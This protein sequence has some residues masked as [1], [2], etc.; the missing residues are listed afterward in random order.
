MVNEKN[1]D[2][3]SAETVHVHHTQE[4]SIAS[5]ALNHQFWS[6]KEYLF[7][8][9]GILI[10]AIMY[11]FEV[12]LMYGCIGNITA[13]FE[14]SSLSS[15]LPTILQIL[16][17]ALVPFYTKVSDVTGRAQALTFAMVFYLIGYTIQGTS[18][19]FLQ[20]ALG[21]IAYGIGSTG[22]ATL[23]QV[24]I[25]DSTL[26]INR[27]IVFAL[28][29]LPSAAMIFIT[30]PLIDPLSNFVMY[31][32][33]NWRNVYLIIGLIALVGAFA[34]LTPLWY[35]QRK[36]ERRLKAAGEVVP[37]RTIGWL[38]HEF[39]TV[40]ALLITLGMSLTLLPMILARSF[41][42]NWGNP[43]ILAMFICGVIFLFLLV[44]WEVK[45]TDRPIMSMKIWGNRTAFGGLVVG[46]VMTVMASMNWQYYTLYLVVSRDISFSSALLL[47]RGY[48]LAYL[49]F[50]LGTALLMKRFNT[51]RP[52]IWVGIVVHTI[53]I[54]LM[55]P[56]RHPDSSNF[57]VVITQTIVGAAGGMAAI[58][59]Q[60][61]V[62]GVVAKKD[63]ATVVGA[64]QLMGSFGSAFGSALSGGIWTQYLPGRLAAHITA[65]YDEVMA[66][67]SPLIY[68]PTLDAVTR[69]Q[70]VE[71]YSDSQKLMSII[72][73]AIAVCA[74]FCAFMMQHV[75]LKQD[76]EE[77][78]RIAHGHPMEEP[79]EDTKN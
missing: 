44:V 19:A 43:R 15:T 20:F 46:F 45:F 2:V 38:L 63:I 75:D 26:L 60:V 17:A 49:V 41:E 51:L 5:K 3:E 72:S 50:Q 64:T 59:S 29:D 10:Q 1:V 32:D 54:G 67:N 68:I 58:A 12:N 27:G 31:P 36:G 77:Q 56:A 8:T 16:S 78:D 11:A 76:Q 55:I 30:N 18:N 61:A 34:V 74:C 52:F 57:F 73:C 13:V 25:A 71:A 22:M 65:P 4:G 70:L 66:M 48:Q 69:R 35:L 9:G 28:W 23:T 21:Q 6:R 33:L 42:G 14:A 37:R 53:G 62:T 24:L 79:I 47:E 39:D 40:G 7:L